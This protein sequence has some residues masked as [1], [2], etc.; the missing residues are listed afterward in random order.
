[1]RVKKSC[2]KRL[3]SLLLAGVLAVSALP[4]G[5]QVQAAE[6]EPVTITTEKDVYVQGGGDAD[7]V[8]TGTNIVV[9]TPESA[10]LNTTYHRRGLIEFDLTNAPENC[11]TAV[12]VLQVNQLGKQNTSTD[13]LDVYT[14]ET[15]WDAAAMTWNNMPARTQEE[16]V[17]S[18]YKANIDGNQGAGDFM[19][20]DISNAVMKALE[21]GE[22]AI[23][24][25]LEFPIPQ[26]GDHAY[27]FYRHNATDGTGPQLELSFDEVKDQYDEIFAGL[28]E[29]WHD[30]IVG[31]DLDLTDDVISNYVASVHRTAEGYYA[32]MNKS[33]ETD[34][35]TLWDSL[36]ITVYP[37]SNT[38]K[39][40]NLLV[41]INMKQKNMEN[42][43]SK[44][45]WELKQ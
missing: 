7:R 34:R 14:T 5:I 3:M 4:G 39:Q 2:R 28:R 16:A 31:G 13:Q 40:K 9:K 1:M 42:N 33:D 36:P 29:K 26:G 41:I 38:Q 21:N 11:N 6:S 17:A 8:M 37:S 10:S 24:L 30:Y 43:H 23:S 45:K 20:I 32:D 35:T 44:L 22:T 25:E 12:L 15:G 19:R 18:A 27:Y